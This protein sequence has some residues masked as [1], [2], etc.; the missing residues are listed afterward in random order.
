MSVGTRDAA[1]DFREKLEGRFE[2]KIQVV[3]NGGGRS[4]ACRDS[5][6]PGSPDEVSEARVL[7]RIVRCLAEGWEIEADQRHVDIKVRDVGLSDAKPVSTP[8]EPETRDDE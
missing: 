1:T 2:I 5:S 4:I 6:K 3:G 7:N 8:G